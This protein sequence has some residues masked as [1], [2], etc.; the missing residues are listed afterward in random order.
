MRSSDR[1]VRAR[2]VGTLFGR[3][4]TD[5]LGHLNAHYPFPACLNK[6]HLAELKT[7]N[8]ARSLSKGAILFRA[9][10]KPGG[11]YVVLEGSAKISVNSEQGKTMVLGLF[12]PGTILGLAASVSG[13]AHAA[14]AE[15]LKPTKVLFVSREDLVRE[16]RNDATAARQTAELLSEACYFTLDKMRTVGL[17]QSAG[18]R[19]ARCL[20]G[21]LAHVQDGEPPLKLSEETIA[22]MVGVSRETVSRLISRLRKDRVLDGHGS[23]LVIQDKSALEKLADFPD[24]ETPHFESGV[25]DKGA[26][27]PHELAG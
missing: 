21:L 14:T 25:R 18:Q 5:Q 13:R 11:I 26:R 7:S 9:G 6:T 15:T 2:K 16:I 22:Q 24:A 1:N 27:T 19:L 10:D 17:S 8:H 4:L 23:G 12:G 3:P 20:L